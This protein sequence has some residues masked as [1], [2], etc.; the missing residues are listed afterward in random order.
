MGGKMEV[1]NETDWHTLQPH[2]DED[3]VRLDV[4]RSFIYY[5]NSEF[6]FKY[7]WYCS[8]LTPPRDISSK[9]L[10][11][12]KEELSSLI[13]DVLRRQ[14]YLHYFQ[15][16]HDIC[17]VVL[18][19]LCPE[20]RLSAVTRLSALRIRDFMLPTLA[21]ALTQLRLIPSILRAV[22]RP[23]YLHL[24]KTQ[25][26]FALS[27]TLTMYAHDIQEYGDI[28]RLYDVL[29]AQPAVF[30]LYLFAAIVLQRSDELFETPADEPEML[31]SIL[32]KLPKPLD[33]E[34]LIQHALSLFAEYPPETLQG[35]RTVSKNS[36]LRTTL[37]PVAAEMQSVEDGRMFFEA[38][39]RELQWAE[40]R[41]ELMKQVRRYQRPASA[42][43]IAV[44][45]GVV[46]FYIRKSLGSSGLAIVPAIR[47]WLRTR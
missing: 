3:Q 9:E 4:D 11:I 36:V 15:G 12:R 17:Q 31:H 26:F 24:S 40:R 2:S 42:V 44:L 1:K 19:V 43:G 20:Q 37:D 10:A 23:L 45:V 16:Y 47:A 5:P 25:P 21:P 34:R 18:L 30:S 39:V 6:T 33:L 27:G 14:P 35:W 38:Q 13:T 28:A 46:S 29:L 41:E 7:A 32:S 8:A 22:N